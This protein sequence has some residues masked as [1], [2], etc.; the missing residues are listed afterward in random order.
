MEPGEV[1]R[2][3]DLARAAETHVNT[4]RFYEEMEIGRA[5]V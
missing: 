4:V 3:A 1:L 2:T 5:H